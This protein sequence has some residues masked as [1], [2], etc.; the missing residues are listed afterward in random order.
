MLSV[1][2]EHL[3]NATHEPQRVASDGQVAVG[4][5]FGAGQVLAAE[6]YAIRGRA[7]QHLA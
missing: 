7:V 5:C 6:I 1:R 2:D 3:H 4:A